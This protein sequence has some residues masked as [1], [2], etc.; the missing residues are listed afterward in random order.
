MYRWERTQVRKV[1]EQKR[2]KA[3]AEEDAARPP[4]QPEAPPPVPV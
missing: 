4:P 1:E 2:L 3:Q